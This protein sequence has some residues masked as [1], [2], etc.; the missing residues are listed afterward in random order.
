MSDLLAD[1]VAELYDADP[2]DF[3]QRRQE[4]A[5]AA[6]EAGQSAAAQQISALRKPTR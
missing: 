6:R 5:A 2:E 1:A 4:L 3:T